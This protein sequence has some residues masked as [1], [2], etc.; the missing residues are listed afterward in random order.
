MKVITQK[1][2]RTEKALP[3][4]LYPLGDAA[5]V[6]RFGNTISSET[7][8]KI[9]AFVSCLEKNPFRGMIELVPAY[10]T[11]TVYY[12]PW[13]LSEKGIYNPYE[14]VRSHIQAIAFT[15]GDDEEQ[16][17]RLVEIPVC[18]EGRHSPDI[19][20]VARNCK[21]SPGEVVA[22]HSGVEYLVHMI[23]FVPGFPYLGGMDPRIESPRKSLPRQK[24]PAGSVGIA[25]R[26]TG[27]YPLATP[28]GWQLIGRTPIK[29]F[30]ARAQEPSLLKAGDRVRF[31]PI[32]EQEYKE[33][34]AAEHES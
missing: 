23:G 19:E 25:G 10:C 16:L 7:H 4:E 14:R 22:I 1:I 8:R 34:K 3:F 2:N 12:N 28:G 17:G 6:L 9:K 20:E 32:T 21:L 29:L 13:M 15:N 33:R 30:Q 18:Y 24:I 26:Q 11:I 5:V 31:V 27:V